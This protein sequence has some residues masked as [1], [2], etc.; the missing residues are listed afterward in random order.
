MKLKTVFVERV[1]CQ[2]DY[3]AFEGCSGLEFMVLPDPLPVLSVLQ[4]VYQNEEP[5][6]H[7][8]VCT[9]QD[10]QTW[11]ARMDL[12][13]RGYDGR[14]LS[15]L[16]QLSRRVDYI[17]SWEVLRARHPDV[18]MEDLLRVLPIA[19][20]G[21]IFP[22]HMLSYH[23]DINL[24]HMLLSSSGPE[25]ATEV[26]HLDQFLTIGMYAAL[27][28]D[29]NKVIFLPS[30]DMSSN[31]VGEK[32]GAEESADASTKS[33]RSNPSLF[34]SPSRFQAAANKSFPPKPRKP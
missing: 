1:D 10:F 3:W 9:I 26:A 6:R 20:R 16:Y 11:L 30:T 29:R 24:K 23:D 33:P 34:R 13:K 17:C 22:E 15:M 7:I 28:R 12:D 27:M 5:R 25:S 18:L 19:K 8:T 31:N 14:D 21:N 2:L 32:L 4:S